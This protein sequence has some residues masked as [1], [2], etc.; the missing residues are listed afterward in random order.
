MQDRPSSLRLGAHSKRQ[1]RRRLP[2]FISLP[3]WVVVAVLAVVAFM[4]LVAWDDFGPFALANALNG[5]AYLPVWLVLVTAVIGRRFLLAS[6]AFLVVVAQIAFVLPELTASEP[7]PTWADHAPTIRLFD[8]N[9]YNV[10]PSMAGYASQIKAAQPQLVTMEEATPTD[11]GQLVASGALADLPYRF[12]VRRY[13]PTAFFVAS[14]YPLGHT[15]VVSFSGRPL[16]VRTTLELPSGPQ[17]LWVVHTTAPLGPAFSAWKGMLATVA[18][19]T[20]ARG[21][22]GLLVVGDFNATWGNRSFRSILDVGLTDGAAA[23]G[24]ALDMTWSQTKPLLPP[25]VR[26]DHLL[27]GTGVAVTQIRTQDGP[28]SDH[29]DLVATVAVR[30][31]PR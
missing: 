15:D 6:A 20:R 28:G 24:N 22:A 3:L 21:A 27:T 17:S 11:V 19:L 25:L 9:V 13:D 30:R 18:H 12:E 10:N 5:V 26:I 8:A 7:I 29:R 4:R 2:L 14:K 16:L 23:R 1:R 31:P